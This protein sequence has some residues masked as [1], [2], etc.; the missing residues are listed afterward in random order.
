MVLKITVVSLLRKKNSKCCPLKTK[1]AHAW[2]KIDKEMV[3]DFRHFS[4]DNPL[5]KNPY[6]RDIIRYRSAHQKKVIANLGKFFSPIKFMSSVE[7]WG[8]SISNSI[9]FLDQLQTNKIL[10]GKTLLGL[11]SK[12]IT[13]K[14]SKNS[15]YCPLV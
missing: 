12:F 13:K 6:S 1:N 2:E 14:V 10:L 5:K 7:L 4:D 9:L 11:K 3:N 15:Y 8:I